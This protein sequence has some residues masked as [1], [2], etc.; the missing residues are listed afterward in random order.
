MIEN[1]IIALLP[2]SILL[3]LLFS[4]P[5]IRRFIPHGE[6]INPLTLSLIPIVL[7]FL[8]FKEVELDLPWLFFSTGLAIDEYNRWPLALLICM[9][10]F[11]AR[12]AMHSQSPTAYERSFLQVALALHI[13]VILSTELVSFFIYSSLLAYTLYAA[14]FG[15]LDKS[16]KDPSRYYIVS[17]IIADL[18]LFEALLVAV[19]GISSLTYDWVQITMSDNTLSNLYIVMVISG[20]MLKGGIW[21][22][23][24]WLTQRTRHPG[25][26]YGQLLVL[27]LVS[28]SLIGLLRWLPVE[29]SVS[30]FTSRILL[31][32]GLLNILYALLRLLT[33]SNCRLWPAWGCLIYSGALMIYLG[34]YFSSEDLVSDSLVY[35]YIWLFTG[36][37]ILSAYMLKSCSKLPT[38][39]GDPVDRLLLFFKTILINRSAPIK[40]TIYHY[41][42]MLE[43]Y[44]RLFRRQFIS[45]FN[46]TLYS[47]H[48]YGN[49]S[50]WTIR[51]LIVVS[52]G[53]IIFIAH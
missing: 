3:P 28:T 34:L 23:H 11:I 51:L 14:M 21:P 39:H 35:A 37:A 49:F 48:S 31:V 20:F 43:C 26:Q 29:Q 36:G 18:A 40:R 2:V 9:W 5:V 32:I 42:E 45:H 10:V 25:H 47:P 13:A 8:S 17:I 15:Q 50:G 6:W 30:L 33:R 52:I 19:Q 16:L 27:V 46:F 22:M 44:W 4:A 38:Q 24:I 41:I 12:S 53:L 7:V 1:L